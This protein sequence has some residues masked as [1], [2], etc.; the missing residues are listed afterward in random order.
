MSYFFGDDDDHLSVIH[1]KASERPA[2]TGK[3]LAVA[4]LGR[5]LREQ[6]LEPFFVALAPEAESG[7]HPVIHSGHEFVF[8]LSG[9]VQYEVDNTIYELQAGDFL[10]FE[11]ELPHHWRNT[12]SEKAEL[13]LILQSSHGSNEPVRRHFSSYPSVLHIGSWTQGA[14]S[15]P[16]PDPLD[17][18]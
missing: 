10:L 14:L 7:P 13:L 8:C 15:G 18:R 11:A 2:L 12:S 17:G 6:E 5:R 9:T 1:V 4:S 16:R 3:G